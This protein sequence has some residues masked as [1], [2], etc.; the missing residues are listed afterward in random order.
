ML[1]PLKKS[2]VFSL[3]NF[4]KVPIITYGV[5]ELQKV[6]IF[7]HTAHLTF[8]LIVSLFTSDV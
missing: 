7:E 3:F 4:S 8:N 2:A 1:N 6:T 5:I